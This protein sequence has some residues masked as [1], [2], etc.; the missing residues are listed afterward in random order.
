MYK[1]TDGMLQG[2]ADCLFEESDGYVLVDYKTD[3]VKSE[4]EL[5]E[6]YRGQLSLYKSAFGAILDKP[7][8][9]AYIYSFCLARGIEIEL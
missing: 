7:I 2:I 5:I 3:R 9:S 8:K 6:R 4:T 1:D